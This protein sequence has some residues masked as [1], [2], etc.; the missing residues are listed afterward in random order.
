MRSDAKISKISN[1]KKVR[2]SS[3]I[4]SLV[5]ILE[6]EVLTVK[7][8]VPRHGQIVRWDSPTRHARIVKPG[9]TLQSFLISFSEE[10]VVLIV[11][12]THKVLL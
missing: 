11:S 6:V 5:W 12:F 9:V 2:D 8:L 10:G 7:Y 1:S 3:R 4:T